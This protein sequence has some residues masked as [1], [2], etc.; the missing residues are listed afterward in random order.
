MG[1]HD[2]GERVA[3]GSRADWRAW[4]EIH[5]R[6]QEGVWAVTWK[7]HMGPRYVPQVDLIREALCFG[8]I[9]SLPRKLDE[10]R[11]MLWIAPRKS[12]SGWSALNKKLAAELEAAGLMTP[13][14]RKKIAAAK[15]DGSWRALDAAEALT[16]PPDLETALAGYADAAGHF[17]AFPRSVKRGILEWIGNAKRPE[18][19]KRR[20]EET[21]RLAD[22]NIRANQWRDGSRKVL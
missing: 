8:W 13:A 19:R 4:L 7:K 12:G 22:K 11:T 21:A 2:N 14:G 1:A 3:V 16:I 5:H 15:K 10:N 6:R 20:V 9:D 17:N 18:T